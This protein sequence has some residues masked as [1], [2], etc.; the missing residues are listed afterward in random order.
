VVCAAKNVVKADSIKKIDNIF[1]ISVPFSV[2]VK[3]D[4]LQHRAGIY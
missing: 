1:F 3:Q 2:I 4:R